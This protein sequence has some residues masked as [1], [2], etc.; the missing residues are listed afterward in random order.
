V[1]LIDQGTASSSEI[2]AGALQDYGRAKLIGTQSYGKGSEQAFI[3][4]QNDQGAIGVTSALWLTPNKRSIDHLGLTP[5]IFVDFTEADFTAKRDAQLDA[6]VQALLAIVSG[7]PLPTSMPSP[8][9]TNTIVPAPSPL[10]TTTP[11]P[12]TP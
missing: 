7:N 8:T 10:P 3:P 4:L 9:P 5:D 2:V 1:V 12:A 11:V 6:A